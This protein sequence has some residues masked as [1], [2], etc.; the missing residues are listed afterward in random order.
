MEK[1]ESSLDAVAREC[2]EEI[3]VRITQ[4]EIRHV[5]DTEMFYSNRLDRISIHEW[6]PSIKPQ[7]IIDHRE[8]VEAKWFSLDDVSDLPLIPHLAKYFSRLKHYSSQ[9]ESVR[10]II[11]SDKK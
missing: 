9:N 7:V 10:S 8:I 2:L 6:N 4:A 5:G 11:R 1:G 3:G